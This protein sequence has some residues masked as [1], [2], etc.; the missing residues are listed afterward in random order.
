MSMPNI[1]GKALFLSQR[2]LRAYVFPTYSHCVYKELKSEAVEE[3]TSNFFFLEDIDLL[4][5][6]S[7]GTDKDVVLC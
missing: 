4:K 3:F 6:R 5:P 7:W 2:V 1:G